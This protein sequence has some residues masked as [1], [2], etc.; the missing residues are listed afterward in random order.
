MSLFRHYQ[1]IRA[2]R[3]CPILQEARSTQNSRIHSVP[4][5]RKNSRT[6][7]IGLGTV[8]HR[9]STNQAPSPWDRTR[10]WA[11]ADANRW[12]LF[13]MDRTC[14]SSSSHHFRCLNP[15]QSSN[16]VRSCWT[17]PH[18]EYQGSIQTRCC[19]KVQGSRD[20][21]CQSTR[22]HHRPFHSRIGTPFPGT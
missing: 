21:S 4:T 2:K 8:A 7:W 15:D 10:M 12:R 20:H 22:R 14:D 3:I 11:L 18:Q 13:P 6:V 5:E 1:Q 17:F 9:F 19:G 16:P